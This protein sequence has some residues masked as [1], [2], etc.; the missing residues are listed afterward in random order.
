MCSAAKQRG[1]DKEVALEHRGRVPATKPPFTLADIRRA[2]PAHCFQKSTARSLAY[3]LTDLLIC[4]AL[5]GA[6]TWIDHPAVP[7]ALAWCVLWP[8]YWFCQVRA[9]PLVLPAPSGRGRADERHASA[10][11][12]GCWCCSWTRHCNCTTHTP[13]SL[14]PQET[15]GRGRTPQ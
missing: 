10:G 7:R 2:V 3:L 11:A 13:H 8:L 4:A 15:G 1:G 14:H 6:A 12:C 9:G 5:W